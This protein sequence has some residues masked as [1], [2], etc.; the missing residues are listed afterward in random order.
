[1]LLL[2]LLD[3]SQWRRVVSNSGTDTRLELA[4]VELGSEPGSGRGRGDVWEVSVGGVSSM[5][6]SGC[7]L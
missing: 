4:G 7:L 1:V 6:S 3:W 5:A 2:V